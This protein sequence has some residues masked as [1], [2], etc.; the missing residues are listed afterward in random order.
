MT[1]LDGI[2]DSMDMSLSGLWELVKDREAWCAAVRGVAKSPTRLSDMN[3]KELRC[4]PLLPAVFGLVRE[5]GRL[6][7]WTLPPAPLT[8]PSGEATR[9]GTSASP[10]VAAWGWMFISTC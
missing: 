5:W 2:T 4:W 3:I 6:T 7:P 1:W 10:G 9:A 8:H